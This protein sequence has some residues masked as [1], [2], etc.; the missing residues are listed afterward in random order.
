MALIQDIKD[1]MASA[2]CGTPTKIQASDGKLRVKM[3]LEDCDRLGCLFNRL[4]LEWTQ[5]SKLAIDP[6]QIESR[7]TYLGEKLRLFETE[8][9]KGKT[10]LRSTPPRVDN[11]ATSFFEMVLNPSRGLSLMR[12]NFDPKTGERTSVAVPLARETV[13]RLIKDLITITS[14]SG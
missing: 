1:Q 3:T 14:E 5:G 2:A 13:E 9:E 4:D 11:E 12:C 8:G 7:V 6:A 10:V